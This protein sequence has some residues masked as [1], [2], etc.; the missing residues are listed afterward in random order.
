[1]PRQLGLDS[2]AVCGI[3]P[4]RAVEHD[5]PAD[6]RVEKFQ[7]RTERAAGRGPYFRFGR[8]ATCRAGQSHQNPAIS[9]KRDRV[10]IRHVNGIARRAGISPSGN[11]DRLLSGRC[12][13]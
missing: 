5:H 8:T 6:R 3:T 2:V 10:Q 9:L 7:A 11:D 13:R 1:M 4:R 12:W